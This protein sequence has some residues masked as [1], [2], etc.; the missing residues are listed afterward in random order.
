MPQLSADENGEKALL[1]IGPPHAGDTVICLSTLMWVIQSNKFSRITIISNDLMSPILAELFDF[2]EVISCPPG[3]KPFYAPIWHGIRLS[4]ILANHSYDE[5]LDLRAHFISATIMLATW[6]RVRRGGNYWATRLLSNKP[7]YISR[8]IQYTHEYYAELAARTLKMTPPGLQELLIM[9]QQLGDSLTGAFPSE[10]RSGILL[11]PGASTFTKRWPFGC[12][13]RLAESL[14][15]SGL[16]TSFLIAKSDSFFIK[17]IQ[18]INSLAKIGYIFDTSLKEAAMHLSRS[19]IV[20]ACDSVASHLAFMV[21]TPVVTIF[22]PTCPDNWY[23][24][25]TIGN[26]ATVRL[27]ELPECHPCQKNICPQQFPCISGVE[28]IAVMAEVER[29]ATSAGVFV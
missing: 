20:I 28:V 13:V 9:S 2:V 25:H 6:T 7:L 10:I 12:W 15:D 17:E 21:R 14:I 19:A 27:T 22:G 23:P 5:L 4:L 16:K 3:Y 18:K 24:Y 11:C 8:P 1:I 29:I 26:A